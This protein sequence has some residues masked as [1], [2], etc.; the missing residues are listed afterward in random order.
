MMI[1][2]YPYN[3]N[4]T[5]RLLRIRSNICNK[6]EVFKDLIPCL[7]INDKHNA[8]VDKYVAYDMYLASL[9]WPGIFLP[10][11]H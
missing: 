9:Y 2:L 11:K 6:F 3:D 10:L 8:A 7:S 5:E 4:S 1:T